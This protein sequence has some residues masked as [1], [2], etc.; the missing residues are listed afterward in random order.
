[1]IRQSDLTG[2]VLAHVL[3]KYMN[4]PVALEDMGRRAHSMARRDAAKVIVDQ[5]VEMA[6]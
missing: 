6:G 3:M 4:D 5:L 2:K 1:M